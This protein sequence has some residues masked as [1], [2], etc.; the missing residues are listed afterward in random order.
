MVE[1][2]RNLNRKEACAY[3]REVH[4]ITRAPSTLAKLASSG[5]GPNFQKAGKAPLYPTSE[6]DLWAQK[7]LSPLMASTSI[8]AAEVPRAEG[9]R[10]S[11]HPEKGFDGVSEH[12][13]G[14]PQDQS[15]G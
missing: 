7:I 11:P 5:G 1:S 13:R 12:L 2:T 3:L 4:G 14:A 6:L 10:S 9:G 15:R 8:K